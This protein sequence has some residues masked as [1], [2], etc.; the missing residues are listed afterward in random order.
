MVAI[1]AQRDDM[2]RHELT[3]APSSPSASVSP[4]ADNS[5]KLG[6]CVEAVSIRTRLRPR[7]SIAEPIPY[8]LSAGIGLA[9]VWW[10]T[11]RLWVKA[12]GVESLTRR[13]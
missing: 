6:A 8:R 4:T 3:C 10:K 7:K 1:R 11:G 9:A 13:L 2:T 5:S 12:S